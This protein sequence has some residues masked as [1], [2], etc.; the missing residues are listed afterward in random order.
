MDDVLNPG[1]IEIKGR[2]ATSSD[3]ELQEV[4]GIYAPPHLTPQKIDIFFDSSI[5][6]AEIKGFW[7]KPKINYEKFRRIFRKPNTK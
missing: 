2:A 7:G 6:F 5:S 1:F 4:S 3:Q